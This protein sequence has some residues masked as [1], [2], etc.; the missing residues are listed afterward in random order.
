MKYKRRVG[1][2]LGLNLRAR[3]WFSLLKSEHETKLAM[4][5]RNP[6]CHY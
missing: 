3:S 1:L 2:G 6:I 5:I 4:L